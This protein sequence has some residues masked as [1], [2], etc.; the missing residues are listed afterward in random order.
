MTRCTATTA[1][2]KRTTQTPVIGSRADADS[3]VGLNL[4]KLPKLIIPTPGTGTRK[5]STSI[6]NRNS[7]DC[8]KNI[9]LAR[10]AVPL[11]CC[12]RR[13]RSRRRRLTCYGVTQALHA[14]LSIRFRT[15]LLELNRVLCN[16]IGV[17]PSNLRLICGTPSISTPNSCLR[18]AVVA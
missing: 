1:L 5:A 6:I 18:C 12:R 7:P 2:K 3:L 16:W 9:N 10:A 14:R 13:Q 4:T 17:L 11:K 15:R 8:G